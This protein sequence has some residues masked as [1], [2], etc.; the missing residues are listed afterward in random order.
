MYKVILF[1]TI[2]VPGFLS[3]VFAAWLMWK[4]DSMQGELNGV[5][6][7]SMNQPIDYPVLV[8]DPIKSFLS[9]ASSEA[10]VNIDDVFKA[11]EIYLSRNPLDA[12]AW[13]IGS[14]LYQQS[15]NDDLASLYLSVAHRLSE[16]NT[17]VLLKVFNRYLELNLIPEAM[18]VA[19]DISIANPSEFRRLFY[20]MSR[21]RDDYAYTVANMIPKETLNKTFVLNEASDIGNVYYQWAMKDSIRLGNHLLAKEIW[22]VIPTEEKFDSAIGVDYL[23][24]LSK[25][26]SVNKLQFVWKDVVGAHMADGALLNYKG[27]GASPCWRVIPN[28]NVDVD[29]AGVDDSTV[30]AVNFLGEANVNYNHLRCL[31]PVK[32]QKKY[33]LSGRFKSKDITTLSGPYIDVYIPGVNKIINRTESIIGNSLWQDFQTDFNVPENVSFVELRVRRRPTN[34]LDS[35]ISGAVWFDSLKL[36]LVE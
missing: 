11:L 28:D 34:L 36:S 1:F 30:L 32:P 5:A 7:H 3:L 35:K 12:E 27:A 15:S 18:P 9:K 31:T 29:I 19:R 16:T 33:R 25:F 21:L 4:S 8:V 13:L 17:P 23:A 6:V 26:Q 20:L 10:N 24:Y 2:M 22:S 14:K